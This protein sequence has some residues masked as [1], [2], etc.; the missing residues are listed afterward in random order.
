MCMG[1]VVVCLFVCLCQHCQGRD[2]IMRG[3]TH[4]V[5]VYSDFVF[6]YGPDA[7]GS[8]FEDLDSDIIR[9]IFFFFLI[10]SRVYFN[11]ERSKKKNVY[12]YVS[13]RGLLVHQG[14]QDHLDLQEQM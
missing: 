9:V 4:F 6:Q 2:S 5:D 8:G 13:T 7:L 1:K 3:I 11:K 14:L 10:I 12:N